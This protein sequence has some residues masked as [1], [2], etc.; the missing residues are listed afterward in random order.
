MNQ[1][2]ITIRNLSK[3]YGFGVDRIEALKNINLDIKTGEVYGIIGRSGAGKSSLIR[4]I[5]M[6]ETPSEGSIF[7]NKLNLTVMTD[8]ELRRARK[9]IGMIFQHFNLLESRTVF[10]NIS[11]PLELIGTSK[12][13]I[14]HRV[15]ELLALTELKRHQKQYANQLSGGQKQRVAIARALATSPKV[16]LCD[17]ATSALDPRS[18]QTILE[19]LKSINKELNITIVLITHEMDVVKEICQSVAVL[20][21]GE[22]IE[23]GPVLDIFT[24]PQTQV[25]KDFI[26]TSTRMDIPKSLRRMLKPKPEENDSRLI[27]ISYRGNATSQPIIGYLI[28]HFK[29]TINI[30]QANI[31]TIQDETVGVL[32]VEVSGTEDNFQQGLIFLNRN[33]LNVEIIGYVHRVATGFA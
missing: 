1:E 27:R 2:I 25:A 22:I 12:A 18:T 26:K 3:Y 11:L 20:H 30:I 9:Q 5:N 29:L 28:S 15:N 23:Q 19:L 13:E 21:E 4:C 31:E 6:L 10:E 8:L 17:E 16:L 14:K 32:V 24:N 33:Q 7:V